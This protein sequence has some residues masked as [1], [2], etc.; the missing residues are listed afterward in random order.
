MHVRRAQPIEHFKRSRSGLRE[1]VAS[2]KFFALLPWKSRRISRG[3]RRRQ[4]ATGFSFLPPFCAFFLSVFAPLR[5]I[6]FFGCGSPLSDLRD[7]L[8]KAF[9][10]LFCGYPSRSSYI[11]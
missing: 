1:S 11:A 3:F 7:L 5:E 8:F 2:V 10:A 9:L 6:L 4:G